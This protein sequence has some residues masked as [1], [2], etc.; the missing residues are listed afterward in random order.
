MR[1]ITSCLECRRR[2]L[3]CNKSQPC[4]NC[5]KFS[6][7]CFYLGP[8]LDEA[9]QQRLTEIKE[10]VG[11]LER[12]LERD[13]A[14]SEVASRGADGWCLYQQHIL[15][16]D[17]EGEFDEE[18]DLEITPMVT[19][20]L[21]YEDDADGMGDVMDL[22]VQ[23]GKMRLTEKIGELNRPRISEEGQYNSF[24]EE[25]TA[26]YEPRSSIQAVVFA[27]WFSAAVAMDENVVNQEFGFT[28]TNL[29]ENMKI[30]TEVALNKAN[31][32]RT[33][34]V[35]T[36]QAFVMYMMQIPL[37]RDEIS[38]AHSVL[39]GAA[40]RMAE[41]L[42]LHRDGKRYNLN[43]LETHVRRLIWHQLCFLD[44]RTCE[45]QGPKPA[46]RREEYDTWLPENCEEEQLLPEPSSN[47][48]PHQ[49]SD[50]WTST[51][52]PLV[53][54]EVNEMMRNIWADR[55]K[56]ESRKITLTQTLTKIERFRKRMLTSYDGLLDERVPMQRYA[57]I[58]MHLLLY[59]L[60]VMILH[61]YYANT[62]SAMPARLRSV[63]IMSSIMIVELAIQLDTNP[64]FKLWRWYAGAYQQYQAA[65]ILATE[66]Y[67]Y[68]AHK[69]AERVWTCLDYVFELDGNIHTEEKG[70]QILT[71]IMGK[72][73]AYMSIRKMRAPNLTASASPA[74]QAVKAEEEIARPRGEA[75]LN[76]SRPHMSPQAYP[77]MRGT[78]L[79]AAEEP[80]VV[81]PLGPGPRSGS[82]FHASS[83]GTP[84][85]VSPLPQQRLVPP[86][87]SSPIQP[88][89]QRGT[90]RPHVVMTNYSREED[91]WS[92]PPPP[93][94][95]DSPEKSSSD[96][97]SVSGLGG[98]RQC[99]LRGTETST[100]GGAPPHVMDREWPNCQEDSI[101]A[102]FPFDPQ[103]GSFA[104]FGDPLNSVN[105]HSSGWAQQSHSQRM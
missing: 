61:P 42:G 5:L 53:R 22:G 77:Q 70:R 103:T 105:N 9:S 54:F 90:P 48:S 4:T 91:L 69:E 55:R 100:L 21:T 1:M 60:H 17:V 46:I 36:M 12:Q 30:A 101:N 89:T 15:A 2:K 13:V 94:H 95:P 43:P 28:K 52:F 38:R 79:P 97:G 83:S 10:K 14:K 92:L 68:P 85:S 27:A 33:T 102:L 80:G 98:Q 58:V 16:D 37:C 104:G 66:I 88:Q 18:R 3:K 6:R 25:A 29:V 41:C 40:V 44:I 8:K 7:D 99:G 73:G 62:T 71:E 67:Y 51:L 57:K 87:G 56:L 50:M 82:A 81:S 76:A 65:L 84:L 31:F 23:V 59:R 64:A 47:P 78:H 75:V 39:V 72:M 86:A 34:K 45:A 19:L 35:E 24:W 49:S 26:G 96:G 93:L 63:L 11:S 32:L 20:D 74:K